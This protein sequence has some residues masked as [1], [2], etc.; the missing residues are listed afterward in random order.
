MALNAIKKGKKGERECAKWLAGLLNLKYVPER[1]LEQVRHG[2][3]D[4]QVEDFIFEVKRCQT[5]HFRKWW[6]QICI[7]VNNMKGGLGYEPIVIYRQNN[8]PWRILISA[9]YIGLEYGYVALG[10]VESK[11]WLIKRYTLMI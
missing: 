9:R 11:Q 8:N 5:L 6:V 10:T 7:A 2:G 3:H 1:N 4:L